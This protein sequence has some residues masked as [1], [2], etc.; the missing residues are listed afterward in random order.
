MKLFSFALVLLLVCPPAWAQ[1]RTGKI[2]GSVQDGSGAVIPGATVTL[3]AAVSGYRQVTRTD[4]SGAF[5]LSNVP[6]DTYTLRVEMAEFQAFEMHLEL[7][8]P[9]PVEVPVELQ[10]GPVTATVE[11]TEDHGE[12]FD[13]HKTSSE[14]RLDQTL[15]VRLP[16][17]APS[18]N[19]EAL[20]A[21]TPGWAVDDNGRLHPRGSESQAQW[22]LDGVPITENL[23]A[24]F[25]SSLDARIM[26][27]VEVLTG[28]LP[29]EFGDKLG[30]VVHVNTRSGIDLDRGS[31]TAGVTQST[32]SFSAEETSVDFAGHTKQFGVLGVISGN[33][34]RRFLDPS[35]AA[36]LHNFGRS[37]RGFLCL[38]WQRDP[39]NWFKV[40]LLLGGTNF[41]V[42]NRAQQHRAEQNQ[43]Q[44]LRDNTEVVSWQ[45]VFNPRWV[46][47]FSG[48]HR[49]SSSGLTSNE[50]AA[51]VL[52]FQ[53]RY[54]RTGGSV[55]AFSYAVQK[56]KVKFGYQLTGRQVGENFT[57]AVTE[58]DVFPPLLGEAGRRIPNPVLR[59]TPAAP[60]RFRDEDTEWLVAVYAQ[61]HFTVTRR[62]TLDIGLR[63]DRYHLLLSEQAVSPRIALAY[64]VPRSPTVLRA[65]Y[66]RLFQLP[67]IENI[68]LASSEEAA[69][70]SP[71]FALQG[72][73]GFRLIRPDTQHVFEG[74]LQQQLG[75][76]FRLD[77]ATYHKIIRNMGDKDQ[78]FDTGIIF[79][80]SISAGRVT[81]FE[82]RLD[83]REIHGWRG[84]LSYANA[85][86]FGI[87]P[88]NGGLF[89]GEAVESLEAPGLRFANDHDQRNSAQFQVTYSHH[90]SGVWAALGG[91][92]DSGYPVPL[93][94]GV[95][96]DDFLAKG[97]GPRLLQE[98]DFRRGRVYPHTVLNFSVGFDRPLSD[99]VRMRAQFDILN[100]T[101]EF[102]LYNF[103]SVFSGTHLGP[104]R[105]YSGR[106]SFH[107][108]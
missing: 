9:V 2:Q 60:F 93:E 34:S 6:F 7:H 12:L 59:F 80:I 38:D 81:G 86:V 25:S 69:A 89:L 68:L 50:V 53:D 21:S 14:T 44:Q 32:G 82:A 48:Y 1:M 107:L 83:T 84:F 8:S 37:A 91:R 45:H 90:R 15:I 65:S 94:E 55:G 54:V 28:G 20:V 58:P 88:V 11:V 13:P 102:F 10:L 71:L 79:P 49:Y 72:E 3:S 31:W 17:A 64:R 24:I 87:T 46:A 5:R 85:R 99:R 76:W 27:S 40:T 61:D 108:K 73:L 56:H 26:R 18:R 19:V 104:P 105:T 62:L 29:A 70:V 33:T 22:N 51:P 30:G 63:W 47:S 43:R 100:L 74:G 23:S 66:N 42:P 96:R 4:E 36:N 41:Q 103:E 92:Y 101:D 39:Y 35:T 98:V 95:T 78:F 16:G 77:L 106:L 67:P 75:P 97:H 57:F 52:A